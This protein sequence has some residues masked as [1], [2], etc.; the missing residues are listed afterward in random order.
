MKVCIPVEGTMVSQHF[1]HT[2]EFLIATIED[3][4]IVSRKVE[5]SPGH[6]PGLLPKLMASWGVTHVITGGLGKRALDL[7]NER[8]IQV[9]S[10]VTGT[11]DE[12]L[13]AFLQG[14]LVAGENL[15]D[16]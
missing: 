11:A 2:P 13:K 8:N 7:F 10:G 14:K 5:K 6:E 1:G 16:H 12:A 4:K 3:G 15:C 9:I